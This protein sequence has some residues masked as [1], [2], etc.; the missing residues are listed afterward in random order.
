M[1]SRRILTAVVAGLALVVA[2]PVA[3]SASS[4]RSAAPEPHL[5]G[6]WPDDVEGGGPGGYAVWN[7]GKVVA[8]NHA[9]H[10]GSVEPPVTDIVGFVADTVDNGYWLVA[11]NGAR[12]LEGIDCATKPW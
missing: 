8:L 4:H 2:L 12:L 7:T 3:A 5:I 1:K 6:I 11:A 10:L 9:P